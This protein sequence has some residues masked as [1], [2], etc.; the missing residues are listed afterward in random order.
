MKNY[1]ASPLQEK[2]GT[3]DIINISNERKDGGMK[4]N[5]AMIS[6]M[7]QVVNSMEYAI[8]AR[9]QARAER[10]AAEAEQEKKAFLEKLR[11]A[12]TTKT[13]LDSQASKAKGTQDA[14]ARDQLM[15][16]MMAGF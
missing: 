11:I 16:L 8:K 5:E 7:Q 6:D 4:M 14:V 1:S 2:A 12:E 3:S 10:R 13:E 15:G 9:S